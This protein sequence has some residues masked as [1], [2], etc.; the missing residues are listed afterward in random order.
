MRNK[1]RTRSVLDPGHWQ[2]PSSSKLLLYVNCLRKTGAGGKVG[3]IPETSE[4]FV[5][6]AI[7]TRTP[8]S[9]FPGNL[10]QSHFHIA[11]FP[12]GTT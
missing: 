11:A 12:L 1:C 10:G 2:G 4:D 7:E 3:C 9:D 5:I 6:G 8:S